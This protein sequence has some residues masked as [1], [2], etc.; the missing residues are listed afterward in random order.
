MVLYSLTCFSNLVFHGFK[1]SIEVLLSSSNYNTF[2][3][4]SLVLLLPNLLNNLDELFNLEVS[5][6]ITKAMIYKRWQSVIPF[7]NSCIILQPLFNIHLF[8]CFLNECFVFKMMSKE[9]FLKVM[10]VKVIK[11]LLH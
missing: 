11:S 4:K 9:M 2:C 3:M 5:A 10:C 6:T 1:Y 8:S 7:S